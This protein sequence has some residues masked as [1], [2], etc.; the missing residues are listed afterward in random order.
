MQIRSEMIQPPAYAI[1]IQRTRNVKEIPGLAGKKGSTHIPLEH[2]AEMQQ[3]DQL[4]R[5][6][7]CWL[8]K[9]SKSSGPTVDEPKNQHK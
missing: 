2:F 4:S 9:V 7:L 5:R 6:I 1:S 8:H 3:T